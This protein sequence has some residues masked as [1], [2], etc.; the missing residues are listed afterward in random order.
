MGIA[1]KYNKGTNVF[2]W[3]AGDEVQFVSLQELLDQNGADKVY[4]V[5]AL[6]IS[7]KSKFGEF[8]KIGTGNM[9]VQLPKHMLDTV[10]AMIGDSECVEAIN[11]GQLGFKIEQYTSKT[12]NKLCYSAVWV[13]VE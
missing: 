8:A 12:Y 11:N 13:D 5:Q 7:D 9:L 1:N 2:N 4:P 10:K 6:F 3:N